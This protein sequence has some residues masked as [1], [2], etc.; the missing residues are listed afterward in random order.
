MRLSLSSTSTRSFVI[1]PAAVAF[2]QGFSRRPL[3]ARWLALLACGYL[4]YR[5]AGEYRKRLGGGGPG[6]SNPPERL[7]TGGI[8][9]FTRN[10]MYLGHLTFLAGLALS[11]RS[12]LAAIFFVGCVPWFYARAAA[13]EKQL[14]A[15]FG[16]HQVQGRSCQLSGRPSCQWGNCAYASAGVPA[17]FSTP[18]P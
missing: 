4:Q 17:S 6:M 7:V 12:P 15:R 14:E 13:D 1:F 8:Y 10:P 11:T 16:D 9:A 3:R 18:A 5:L 2:E